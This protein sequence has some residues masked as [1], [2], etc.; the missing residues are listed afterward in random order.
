MG[1]WPPPS[2]MF[3]SDFCPHKAVLPAWG[4]H[5]LWQP[6][7][8]L[9]WPGEEKLEEGLALGLGCTQP[10]PRQDL[11]GTSTE[12][13]KSYSSL[14]TKTTRPCHTSCQEVTVWL[15]SSPLQPEYQGPG[16]P[17]LSLLSPSGY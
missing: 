16:L 9:L 12:T 10:I 1:S 15:P 8:W 6:C 3:S 5:S 11:I 2:P 13:D 4:T 14:C 7:L 17:S